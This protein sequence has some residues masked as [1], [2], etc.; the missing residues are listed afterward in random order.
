MTQ[1]VIVLGAGGHAGVLLACLELQGLKV[2]GLTDI[3]PAAQEIR[4]VPVIGTDEA[5]LRYHPDRIRLVNGLGSTSLPLVRT[6]LFERMKRE[7][8]HFVSV[9]HPSA[10]IAADA[11]WGEGT[12]IMAGVIIQPG[13][14]L[15]DNCILNTGTA[16]DHDCRLGHHVHLAPRVT[17]SGGVKIGEGV[18]VGTGAVVIQ[19]IEIGDSCL[20]G[21]GSV[22]ID[23]VPANTKVMGV[24]AREVK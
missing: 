7:G 2:I 14:R 22:V 13:C 8:Y 23:K 11:A 10:I 16:L 20:I 1:P 9:I 6:M 18:H 17:L 24:P 4:G 5:V 19:G 15:G 12:Q 3:N 21:A